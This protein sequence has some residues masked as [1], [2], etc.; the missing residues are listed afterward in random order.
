[1]HEAGD[2]ERVLSRTSL[3]VWLE[4]GLLDGCH[5]ACSLVYDHWHLNFI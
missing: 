1:M 4:L 2:A 3:S 5:T